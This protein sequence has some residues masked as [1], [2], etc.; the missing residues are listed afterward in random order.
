M[1]AGLTRLQCNPVADFQMLHI[2]PHF[3]NCSARL[4][5]HAA[6]QGGARA[7]QTAVVMGAGCIGLVTMIMAKHKRRLY[8]I[9]TDRPCLVIMQV[10]AA[11]SHILQL[12]KHL[13]VFCFRDISLHN[14]AVNKELNLREC[15]YG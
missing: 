13:I 4:I 8:H 6:M 7:G 2:L 14:M 9:V 3:H 12:H 10:A 15:D 11:D 1:P 5:F